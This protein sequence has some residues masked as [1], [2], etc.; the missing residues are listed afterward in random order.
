MINSIVMPKRMHRKNGVKIRTR[1]R[2]CGR[3][4]YLMYLRPSVTVQG[5]WM[6]QDDIECLSYYQYMRS[7]LK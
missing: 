1:C 3:C 7:N 4:R 5:K 6:C 2:I